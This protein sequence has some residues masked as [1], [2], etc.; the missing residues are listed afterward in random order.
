[1]SVRAS[2]LISIPSWVSFSEWVRRFFV[3]SLIHDIVRSSLSCSVREEACSCHVH[4][5]PHGQ[6]IL[7]SVTDLLV[8]Y[9]PVI[10]VIPFMPCLKISVFLP[11]SLLSSRLFCLSAVMTD[12]NNEDADA[13]IFDDT[14]SE[15]LGTSCRVATS[16]DLD[17]AF[18]AVDVNVDL[19]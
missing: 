7:T 11:M 6:L 13:G 5:R 1:M 9:F 4:L 17:L 2:N 14:L 8:L 10:F 15:I 3:H 18:G 19:A 12:D 16:P